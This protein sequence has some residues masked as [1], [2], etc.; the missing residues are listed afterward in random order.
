[1]SE[2]S[3]AR[4]APD[5][6]TLRTRALDA[7]AA[8]AA[9]DAP[10]RAGRWIG[11]GEPLALVAVV[12]VHNGGEDIA[13]ALDALLEAGQSPEAIAVVDDGSTDGRAVAAASLRGTR[14]LRLDDGP[15]GPARARNVGAGLF[16]H[17]DAYLFVDADVTVHDDAVRAFRRLLDTEPGVS[18]AFGSYDDTPPARGWISRYKNLLHHW[19]HQ[20]GA[21]EASTFWS[22][23]GIVRGEAFRR[24]G[25]FD[26]GFGAASIE[27]VDLGLRIS[28]A[29]ER[30]LLRP[31]IRCTHWKRWTLMSWLRTDIFA[32]ALPWSRLIVARGRGVPDTLNLGR[33]ER[34]C[35][36]LACG[37]L[38]GVGAAAASALAGESVA[39]ALVVAAAALASFAWLQRPLVAFFARCGG[40]GF[41]AAATAMH[42]LYFVYSSAV[43]GSVVLASAFAPPAR[44]ANHGEAQI[45]SA[46]SAGSSS[47]KSNGSR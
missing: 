5:A 33:T 31:E 15:H 40:V 8:R 19:M 45:S 36:V 7:P 21:G 25:G 42:L 41:A 2:V 11:T 26:E 9:N 20:R 23:C 18:A 10:A 17:A 27:D 38:G 24:H 44:R 6:P 22:G 4:I 46:F 43:Y 35:A 39:A 30:V 3:T 34:V 12:P 47:R 1:M 28:D 37:A 32:R 13:R 29:G 16:P 14:Y